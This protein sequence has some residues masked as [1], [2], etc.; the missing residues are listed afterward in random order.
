MYKDLLERLIW[1]EYLY[2]SVLII[3]AGSAKYR[4][5]L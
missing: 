1:I 4:N 3:K 2:E 5:N